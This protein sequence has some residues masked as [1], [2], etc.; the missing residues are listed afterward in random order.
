MLHKKSK[1]NKKNF[2]STLQCIKLK[3]LKIKSPVIIARFYDLQCLHPGARSPRGSSDG[4]PSML[5]PAARLRDKDGTLERWG[6]GKR[7]AMFAFFDPY[8]RISQALK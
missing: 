7:N 6:V 8:D 4:G 1:E 2:T 5:S 3:S